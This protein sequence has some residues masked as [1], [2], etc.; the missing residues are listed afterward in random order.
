MDG[1]F[2]ISSTSRQPVPDYNRQMLLYKSTDNG[3]TFSL[4]AVAVPGSGFNGEDKEWIY[5]DPFPE[6]PSYNNLMIAWRSFGPSYGIKFR[7]SDVGGANWSSTV[8]VSDQSSGQG[9]NLTTGVD[10]RIIVVWYQDGIRYDIS[11]DNGNSFGTDRILSSY[12]SNI[13]NSWPF[14]CTDNSNTDTHGNIYV[15]WAD[16][17]QNYDDV[18]FQRSTDGGETWLNQPIRVNGSPGYSQYWPVIR[19]DSDGRLFVVYYDEGVD[20]WYMNTMI[21]YSDD[22][23]NT[24]NHQ[25]LSSESF[26]GDA[27]NYNVRFG[28]YIEL[29]VLQ[30]KIIPVWTDDRAGNYNQEIYTAIVDIYTGLDEV[31]SANALKV[32]NYPN[33]FSESINIEITLEEDETIS[34]DIFDSYGKHIE[35]LFEGNL[36]PGSHSF[37]WKSAVPAGIYH[38]K[39]SHSGFTESYRLVKM[40]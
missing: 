33:P 32:V 18:W 36:S 12:S 1:N 29:D 30:G 22:A 11:Y 38:L 4:H 7:K 25:L 31:A 26:P 5:V 13:N 6:S 9:A 15:V 10:G 40:R 16:S 23:G 24:W 14:I 19:C 17:R 27:P 20:P 35:S 8:D 37:N 39:V 34:A 3:Q 21:S 28:D 2:Y